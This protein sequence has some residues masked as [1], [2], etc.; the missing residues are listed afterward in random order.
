MK[1]MPNNQVVSILRVSIVM[2]CF[3]QTLSGCQEHRESSVS[4]QN[5]P[6]VTRSLVDTE[7][8]DPVALRQPGRLKATRSTFSKPLA[9]TIPVDWKRVS[10]EEWEKR[11]TPEEFR[12][13]RRKGTERAFTGDLWDHKGDGIYTC[14]GCGLPLFDSKTKFKSGTGWPSYYAPINDT[15]VASERDESY[16]MVR[17]EVLC[18]RCGGHLGH[19]FNDGPK[20]TGL[21]YCINSASLDFMERDSTGRK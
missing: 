5:E 6:S 10:E 8:S 9:D 20:P 3:T 19:V 2:L 16:G 12:I 11:L 17:T 1:I 21:R 7:G 18:S 13:L 14:G 15:N 4:Q